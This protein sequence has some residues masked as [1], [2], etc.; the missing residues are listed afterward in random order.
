M[1]IRPLMTLSVYFLLA[2]LSTA[3]T[4]NEWL[5]ADEL[6]QEMSNISLFGTV[7]G[8]IWQE[9]ITADGQTQ[10][11][12]ENTQPEIGRL[13][14]TDDALVCFNYGAQDACFRVQRRGDNYAFYMSTALDLDNTLVFVTHKVKRGVKLCSAEDVS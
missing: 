5:S 14:I 1:N 10:Y 12:L 3:Q 2:C 7:E 4:Q 9:C 8:L 6:R 11:T 13:H